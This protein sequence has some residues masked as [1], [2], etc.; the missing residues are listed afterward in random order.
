MVTPSSVENVL[1]P[2][3][4]DLDLPALHK[5]RPQI[6]AVR[7]IRGVGS[8]VTPGIDPSDREIGIR[9][10]GWREI[11]IIRRPIDRDSQNFDLRVRRFAD[12]PA[13]ACF[14]VNERF[15]LLRIRSS[16][17]KS[18]PAKKARHGGAR[19][20]LLPVTRVE[21]AVGLIHDHSGQLIK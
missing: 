17:D 15:D 19:N 12:S 1:A 18:V 13:L 6:E 7:I 5:L 21:H 16:V 3:A 2:V 9:I 10:E 8:N 4:Y 14:Q 11:G 20:V